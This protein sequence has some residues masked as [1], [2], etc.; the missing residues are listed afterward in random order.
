MRVRT[1]R[2][3]RALARLL[4]GFGV[5]AGLASDYESILRQLLPTEVLLDRL[6]MGMWIG[7]RI[8]AVGGVRFKAYINQQFDSPTACY[9]R[10]AMC[11]VQLERR[12]ALDRLDAFTRVAGDGVVPGGVAIELSGSGIGSIE[13]YMRTHSGSPS[14]YERTAAAL[15]C[16]GEERFATY[17]S[18]MLDGARYDPRAVVLSI[19]L[20]RDGTDPS[21]KID[22][23]C[24][25]LF[26]SDSKAHACAVELLERMHLDDSEYWALM[27]TCAPELTKS[28]VERF[29]WLGVVLRGHEQRVNIYL[30]P[31][32]W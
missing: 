19:G 25:R 9:L 8:D 15:G 10:V 17:H 5:P 23:N 16:F 11:L 18:V 2:S 14:Y 32:R 28:I 6:L 31:G 7:V 20:P 12:E 24:L 27:E 29:T 30:H 4:D 1:R 26:D 3:L 22:A 13:L 21:F